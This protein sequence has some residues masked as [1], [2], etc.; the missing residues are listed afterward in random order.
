MNRVPTNIQLPADRGQFVA[1]AIAGLTFAIVN[2]P[3]AM[4]NAVLAT[5]NP[6]AGL[7]TLMIATPI[8]ALFTGSVFMNVSTTGALSVA[9]GDAL[10]GFS[11]D[12]K[13]GALIALV[14]LIGLFQLLA[15][16]L[17]LGSLIRFVAQSVM[18]GFISGIA[19]LIILGAIPDLTGYTSGFNSELLKLA[20]TALNIRQADPLTL[21]LGLLTI[22]LIVGFGY[23]PVRKFSM[24]LALGV[25]TVLGVVAVA[26][27]DEAGLILVGDIAT[28]PR[29]LP[30]PQ[31][32]D[33][34]TI[35]ELVLP[36]LAIAVI[37]LVQGAGVSQSYPNPD[38][39]FPD[40]SRDF[41]GQG[42]ANIATG[43]FSGIPG[44]GSMSGTA[45]TVNAGAYTRWANILAGVFVILIVLLFANVAMLIPMSALAGL[46]VV[47]G[48]QNLQPKQIAL[49]WQTGL[50]ARTAMGLTF[51][52]TIA[53]PL[54]F[55]IMI[56]I[57]ISVMMHVFRSSNQVRVVEFVPVENGFPL[58]QP[59]PAI[60]PDRDVTL[61]YS[62]GSLFFAS[63]AT[64]EDSLPN[65]DETQQAAVVL[66]LR[67]QPDVGSTFISVL[68]RYTTTLQANGGRLM[69]TGVNAR[70]WEQLDKTGTLSLIGRE[71]VF[72]EEAQLGVAMNRAI[73]AAT[74]WL[75]AAEAEGDDR[76]SGS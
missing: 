65:A 9:A 60:L 47:V 32:P 21:I 16:I 56:G 46:L 57:A 36:A 24:I 54:Q 13:T 66:I 31:L 41:V 74:S 6:V 71:N 55:A 62:Y 27:L 7:Y 73:E 20:D 64:F 51:I 38:G 39:K 63:A 58:E 2:V 30:R 52:A 5:V 49:V 4:G 45:V 42:I 14:L 48:F 53:L 22:G 23:T 68:R 26:L 67:G 33:L 15:G 12:A 17:R 34:L 19:V 72:M 18:T 11:G 44:G 10:V 50:V 28:I 76:L 70:L 25:V 3:Q 8:G 1:D 59:A 61:L 69:L 29:S 43:F 75:A 40:V 37:G 35:P